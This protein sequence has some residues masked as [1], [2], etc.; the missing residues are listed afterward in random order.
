MTDTF[1]TDNPELEALF[2]R[3][4][5]A[6]QS[7]VFAPLADGCRKAGML[8][9]AIEICERGVSAH[10]SYASGFVV[11][12]KCYY[13]LGNSDQA[14]ASF[15]RVLELDA[16]NLVAL[17][18]M[19]MIMSERGDHTRAQ[20]YFKSILELDPEDKSIA[21]K[22]EDMPKDDASRESL[23]E[24]LSEVLGGDE[25][26]EETAD[27]AAE[28]VELRAVEDESFVGSEITLSNGDPTPDVLATLT[29]ADIYATQGYRG[30]AA[31]I[32][33]DLLADQPDNRAIAERL[34]ALEKVV[35]KDSE[36]GAAPEEVPAVTDTEGAPEFEPI[37][38]SE[39]VV[40]GP[41][42]PDTEAKPLQ[43]EATDRARQR[44]RDAGTDEAD[45]GADAEE[46]VAAGS[47]EANVSNERGRSQF[48]RWLDNIQR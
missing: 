45:P 44:A 11:R 47:K 30:K 18:F 12:G 10:P 26:I 25:R 15:E 48:Q 28:P 39:T 40:V 5:R 14:E 16:N 3:Y 21:R 41:S 4:R 32:Y 35:E 43:A 29:L 38:E 2:E 6:P 22:L 31:K 34:E 33:R 19:G 13:D 37:P 42:D 17:K 36:R 23:T 27:E 24:G 8:E 46:A 1:K 20:Q 9:E 7:H